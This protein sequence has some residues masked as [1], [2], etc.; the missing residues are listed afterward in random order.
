MKMNAVKKN[1]GNIILLLCEI[2]VGV[3]LLIQPEK[4]TSLIIILAGIALVIAGAVQIVR[5]FRSKPSAGIASQGLTAGL[6]EV[7][8]GAFCALQYKWFLAAFPIL[9]VLYG[10]VMLVLGVGK[11][12]IAV[13]F[14][15]LK[16]SHWLWCGLAS[17]LTVVCAL[18][19]LWNPFASTVALWIFAGVSLIVE[20]VLDLVALLFSGK[21]ET[22]AQ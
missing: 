17:L 3:L 15:R 1:I 7:I 6:L 22:K 4:F 10:I 19:I 5:Y 12:E 2:V 21:E 13:N 9:T 14:A 16:N 8:L 11:I 20:A 18:V